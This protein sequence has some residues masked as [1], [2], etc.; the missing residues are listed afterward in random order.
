MLKD[1]AT[2]EEVFADVVIT[3]ANTVTVSFALAP[4]LNA[5]RVIIKK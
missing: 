5:Y 4:A 3:D 1:N 2:L